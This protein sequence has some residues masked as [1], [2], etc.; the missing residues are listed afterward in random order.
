[1]AT[2][3]AISTMVKSIK[4]IAHD[5]KELN[6]ILEITPRDELL[7]TLSRFLMQNVNNLR[8]RADLIM[9]EREKFYGIGLH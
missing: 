7:M 8:K 4:E 1:M 3:K 9:D 6:S 5:E 2:S